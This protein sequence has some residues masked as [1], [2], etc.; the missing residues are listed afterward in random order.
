MTDDSDDPL[1]HA[2]VGTTATI[3]R[4]RTL[5]AIDSIPSVYVG[6]D[7]MRS[8]VEIVDLELVGEGPEAEIDVTWEGEV[9]KRLPLGWDRH[10]ET[11]TDEQPSRGRR[12]RRTV[13]SYLPLPLTVL[14]AGA[15]SIVVTNSALA[16]LTINGDPVSPISP[17]TATLLT[18]SLTVLA[19]AVQVLLSR[20]AEPRPT[21]A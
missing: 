5:H 21:T 15:L 20:P 10:A 2:D 19:V 12:W 16:E 3:R 8:D 13:R 9:V 4:T 11:A 17:I 7:R 1:E 14:V 18:V 6:S